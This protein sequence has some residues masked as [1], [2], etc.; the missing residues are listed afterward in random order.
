MTAW[1]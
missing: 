1:K